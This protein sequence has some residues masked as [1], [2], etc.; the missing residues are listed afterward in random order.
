MLGGT[1]LGIIAIILFGAL[2]ISWS[3]AKPDDDE[4]D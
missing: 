4:E 1:E 3:R 2:V